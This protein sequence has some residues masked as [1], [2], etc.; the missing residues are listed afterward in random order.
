[1]N[2]IKEVKHSAKLIIVTKNIIKRHLSKSF[3][4]LFLFAE[5]NIP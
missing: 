3:S 5:D 1:M 4:K 2:T